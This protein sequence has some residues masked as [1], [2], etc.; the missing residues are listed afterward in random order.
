MQAS[1]LKLSNAPLKRF[2]GLLLILKVCPTLLQIV[3]GHGY[4]NTAPA[5]KTSTP[6][7]LFSSVRCK[8]AAEHHTAEQ[9][10]KTGRTKLQK[11]LR[12]SDRSWNIFHDF[13]IIPIKSRNCSS[14]NSKKKVKPNITRSSDFFTIVL[15]RV[16][17][18]YVRD[19]ETIIVIVILAFNF[20]PHRTHF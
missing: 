12:S 4:A 10:S 19:L 7:T 16:N 18:V 15:S 2:I 14:G 17:S 6:D 20:I 3:E 13:L 11:H 1:T 5:R 8:S 9:Y